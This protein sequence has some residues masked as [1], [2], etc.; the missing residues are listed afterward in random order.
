MSSIVSLT[1]AR[2]I[3]VDLLRG[4]RLVVQV[5]GTILDV[6][7]GILLLGASAASSLLRQTSKEAALGGVESRVLYTR[8]GMNC[9]DTEGI[10]VGRRGGGDSHRDGGSKK[11][12]LD[13]HDEMW[14][15]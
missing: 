3:D 8:A 1:H 7:C 6:E 5:E 15:C 2:S 13:L 12:V 10:R 9:N 14:L 11:K 4:G